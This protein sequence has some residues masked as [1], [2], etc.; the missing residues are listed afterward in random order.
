MISELLKIHISRCLRPF[1]VLV[2]PVPMEPSG[3]WRLWALALAM[4]FFL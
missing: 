1:N 3:L 2:L 4:S